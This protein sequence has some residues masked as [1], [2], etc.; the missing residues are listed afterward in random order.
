MSSSNQRNQQL[1]CCFGL[2]DALGEVL[3]G[4][5]QGIRVFQVRN[6]QRLNEQQNFLKR[7]HQQSICLV[8]L[9]VVVFSLQIFV[10]P[11]CNFLNN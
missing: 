5:Q 4:G 10:W 7:Q 11:I 3:G 6:R 9:F 2:L 1:L 8:N